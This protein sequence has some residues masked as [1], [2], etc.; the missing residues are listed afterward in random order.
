MNKDQITSLATTLLAI[1]GSYLVGSGKMTSDQ[2]STFTNALMT[3]IPAVGVVAVTLWKLVPHTDANK[4]VAASQV[5]GVLVAVD[6]T[7][8]AAVV[9]AVANDSSNAV[10]NTKA[11]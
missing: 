11:G 4:V 3:A 5:P 2:W 7:K 10:T 8:A 9:T 6:P 1:A